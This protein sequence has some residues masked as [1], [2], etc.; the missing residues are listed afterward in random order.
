MFEV[1]YLLNPSEKW[2]KL[3]VNDYVQFNQLGQFFFRSSKGIITSTEKFAGN[4]QFLDMN[5]SDLACNFLTHQ[6][7]IGHFS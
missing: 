3:T 7:L 1:W 5:N 6:F 2:E 4:L